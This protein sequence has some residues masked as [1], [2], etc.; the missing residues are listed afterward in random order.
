[1]LSTKSAMIQRN[2]K[3]QVGQ[4]FLQGKLHLNQHMEG[5]EVSVILTYHSSSDF[6]TSS[7]AATE[8]VAYSLYFYSIHKLQIEELKNELGFTQTI[9][10]E[11]TRELSSNPAE[12]DFLNCPQFSIQPKIEFPSKISRFSSFL[13]SLSRSKILFPNSRL[14]QERLSPELQRL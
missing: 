13:I 3:K 9:S 1:V 4:R 5:N 11:T 7:K 14:P 10:S 2:F 8:E 6:E 12:L